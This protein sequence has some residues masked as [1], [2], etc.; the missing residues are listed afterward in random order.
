MNKVTMNK[1]ETV[2]EIEEIIFRNISALRFLSDTC[3]AVPI[4]CE[5]DSKSLA[6]LLSIIH[7][8]LMRAYD[9]CE[10]IKEE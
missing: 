5:Q 3:L 2:E 9:L 8:N 6:C 4:D 10:N 7:D 1:K